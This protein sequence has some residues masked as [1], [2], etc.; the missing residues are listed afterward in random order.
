MTMA[1]ENEEEEEKLTAE[2]L[3]YLKVA[4]AVVQS[5]LE[6]K[7]DMPKTHA[8]MGPL[9]DKINRLYSAEVNRID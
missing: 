5:N 8:A 1:Q 7:D 3:M 6:L 9:M 2:D 4:I